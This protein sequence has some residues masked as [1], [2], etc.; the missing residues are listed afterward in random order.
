MPGCFAVVGTDGGW[1][2]LLLAGWKNTVPP[3]ADAS[4]IQ[5]DLN[6]R[7]PLENLA[8]QASEHGLDNPSV[9]DLLREKGATHVDVGQQQGRVWNP[10]GNHI[11]PEQLA[12]SPDYELVYHQDRVWV[13]AVL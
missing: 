3:M 12:A 10:E 8:L 1:W 6:Y 11:N 4:E 13:F 2:L 9:R 7:R 5:L